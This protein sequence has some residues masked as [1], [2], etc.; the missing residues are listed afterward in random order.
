MNRSGGPLG[1]GGLDPCGC[2]PEKVFEF[3]DGGGSELSPEQERKMR[4]H[5]ASCPGCRELYE[6]ELDLNAFLSSLD[7][8]GGC[9]RSVS[10]GVAMALPTRSLGI[11]VLWGLLA[12]AL[13]IVAFA[14]SGFDG[15]KPVILTMSAVGACWDLL[16]GSVAVA[17]MVFVTAGPAI[18]L[19]L[20]L[21]A[22]ADLLIVFAVLFASRYRRAREA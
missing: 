12:G 14:S 20:A 19:V 10:R 6:R 13:L 16:A 22:L 11:R 21:G 2:D 4:E 8:S 17:R 18:L 1:P 9:S 15:T 7:F 3:A 5:L